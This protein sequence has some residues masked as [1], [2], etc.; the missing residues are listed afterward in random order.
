MCGMAI[1]TQNYLKEDF[2]EQ[3]SPFPEDCFLYYLVLD[4]KIWK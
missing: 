2:T 3:L 4:Y 1:S